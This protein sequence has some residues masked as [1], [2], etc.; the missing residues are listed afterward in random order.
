MDFHFDVPSGGGERGI[1]TTPTIYWGGDAEEEATVARPYAIRP[2]T[3]RSY[4]NNILAYDMNRPAGTSYYHKPRGPWLIKQMY[5]IDHSGAKLVPRITDR[6]VYVKFEVTEPLLLSP[7]IFG[8]GYGQQGFY[9]IQSMTFQ[10]VMNGA[11]QT[12]RGGAPLIRIRWTY[13]KLQL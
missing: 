9:G 2:I 3:Y 6:D 5:A 8:S 13:E 12:G 7:F 10:M 4:A 1:P 11:M